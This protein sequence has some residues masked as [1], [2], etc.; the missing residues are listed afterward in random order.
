MGFFETLAQKPIYILWLWLLVIN[1]ALFIT[2][3][4]DKNRAVRAKWRIPE[5]TLL[6]MALIGGS[7]GGLIGMYGFRHKTRHAKF[8]IGF[9]V[10]LILQLAAG[11]FIGTRIK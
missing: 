6:T 10:I 11:I 7:L 3:G 1:L 5:R 2:M 9:P 8:S 4:L